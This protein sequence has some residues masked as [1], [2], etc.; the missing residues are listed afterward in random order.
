MK[1]I[2]LILI[3]LFI[4][5]SC[6]ADE[7]RIPFSVYPKELQKQFADTGRKLDLSGNDRTE[8]SWGFLENKGS[9]VSIFTYY[10]AT[11][12]DLSLIMKLI[13]ERQDG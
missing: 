4:T 2:A 6:L 10:S 3:L 9:N 5:A 8:D 13:M 11:D 12:E 7:F 1:Q